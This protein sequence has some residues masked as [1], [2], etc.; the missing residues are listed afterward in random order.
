MKLKLKI[1]LIVTTLIALSSCLFFLDDGDIDYPQHSSWICTINSDGTGLHYLYESHGNPQYSKDG[2]KIILSIDNYGFKILDAE[3]GTVLVEM[4]TLS[5]AIHITLSELNDICFPAFCNETNSSDLFILNID[6]LIFE[7]L[8]LT[9]S[10]GENFPSYYH[11][12]NKIVYQE[13][14]GNTNSLN[15]IDLLTH[16]II[17]ISTDNLGYRYPQMLFDESHVIFS[18]YDSYYLLNI[19]E[20]TNHKIFVG[21]PEYYPS[22]IFENEMTFSADDHIW[23]MNIDGSELMDLGQGHH[24]Q[25]S[26][27]GSKIAYDGLYIMNIDGTN[28]QKLTDETGEYPHF[29]PDGSKIVFLMEKYEE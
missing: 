17:V 2:T 15:V 9:D 24:P 6:S 5:S 13:V 3:L 14:V 28:K 26:P 11:N 10:I 22:T 7:N 12:S 27:D 29:S 4:D 1:L 23:K 19:D 16:Q 18:T 20:Q 8:T 21:N 25:F